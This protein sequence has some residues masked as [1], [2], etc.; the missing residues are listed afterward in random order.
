MKVAHLSVSD[1]AGGA[2]RAAGQIHRSV[3]LAGVD[4]RIFVSDTPTLAGS[5]SFA[6]S[7]DRLLA[8]FNLDG[9]CGLFGPRDNAFRSV[10]LIPTSAER[11]IREW[12]PDIIHLHWVGRRTASIAQLGRLMKDFPL[13]WSL[14]DMWPFLGAEHYASEN[15][16]ARWRK[17]DGYGWRKRGLID[18]DKWAFARKGRHWKNPGYL[19]VPNP[20]LA[21]LVSESSLMENWPTQEVAWPVDTDV[22]YPE[23]KAEA[24]AA[25]GVN[26]KRPVILF[27]SEKGSKD[28]RKGADLLKTAV[29]KYSDIIGPCTLL[30]FGGHFELSETQGIEL[31]QLGTLSNNAA[32]RQAYNAS[33][34]VVIP[35]RQDNHSLIGIEAQLCGVPVVG[36]SNSGVKHQIQE[37]VT[38]NLGE[39]GDS[40]SLANAIL[41]TLTG[42]S[43]DDTVSISIA[44]TAHKMHNPKTVGAEIKQV[45]RLAL[46]VD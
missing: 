36:F 19:T 40:E 20:W 41:R 12:E 1:H 4:S 6:N 13:V 33:D 44:E 14:H 46:G 32:L 10:A 23:D 35:S 45:Y 42:L 38:G 5:E 2:A 7:F 8:L 22:F 16:T 39:D 31:V 30:T 11:R 43:L 21:Q 26:T 27:G 3:L 34:V 25:L 15:A 17:G 28:P 18:I 29:Q 24:K 37:S 9:R